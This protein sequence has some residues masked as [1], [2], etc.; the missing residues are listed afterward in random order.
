MYTINHALSPTIVTSLLSSRL[1][2]SVSNFNLLRVFGNTCYVQILPNKCMTREPHARC[3]FLWY[4]IEHKEYRCWN[5]ISSRLRV[6]VML[7]FGNTIFFFI[8]PFFWIF[9]DFSLFHWPFWRWHIWLYFW[10]LIFKVVFFYSWCS[11]YGD[12]TFT[13]SNMST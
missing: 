6:F 1:H 13:A 12:T 7:T 11:Y 5:H 8:S 9:S 10:T 4:G 2:D 3:C